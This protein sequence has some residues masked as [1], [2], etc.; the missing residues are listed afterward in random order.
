MNLFQAF[1]HQLT[2]STVLHSCFENLCFKALVIVTSEQICS[3]MAS[4]LYVFSDNFKF[5]NC[6]LVFALVV[7]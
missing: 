5:C 4:R 6:S 1:N 7:L 3:F 2:V